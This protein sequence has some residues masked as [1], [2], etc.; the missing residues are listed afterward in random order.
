MSLFSAFVIEAVN[1]SLLQAITVFVLI[2][3]LGLTFTVIVNVGPEQLPVTP[4]TGVTV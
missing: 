2:D 1:N 4:D 3:G